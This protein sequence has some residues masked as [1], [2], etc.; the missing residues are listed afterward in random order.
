VG[1]YRGYG[2]PYRY[3]RYANLYNGYYNPYYSDY[4]YRYPRRVFRNVPY[5][6]VT[7][8]PGYYYS[9]GRVWTDTTDDTVTATTTS[10]R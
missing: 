4:Y 8:V 9:H 2:Y 1:F 3:G 6:Y 10:D 7:A 5:G